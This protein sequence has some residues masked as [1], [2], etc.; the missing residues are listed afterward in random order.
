MPDRNS[1]FEEI[2]FLPAEECIEKLNAFLST[3]PEDDEALTLRGMKNWSLNRRQLAINDYLKAL[4]INPHSKAK[5][6]LD[7]ANSILDYYNKDLLN[8]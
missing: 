8:P 1:F 2:R 5:T 6:A 4:S 7:Y 3:H